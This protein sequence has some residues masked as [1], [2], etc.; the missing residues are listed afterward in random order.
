MKT[1]RD[2]L[3]QR[4]QAAAARLDAV[5]HGVVQQ[6][7]GTGNAAEQSGSLLDLLLSF[8]R[9]FAA[10]AAVWAVVLWLRVDSSEPARSTVAGARPAAASSPFVLATLRENR[11]LLLEMTGPRDAEPPK[12]VAP[13]PHSEWRT[14]IVTA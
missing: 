12:T 6:L 3:L 7:R 13:R 1:P 4:H 11:R 9:H 5:R 14:A 2:I 10:L 8:R